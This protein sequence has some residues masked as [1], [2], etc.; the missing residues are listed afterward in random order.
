MRDPLKRKPVI[1]KGG[2]NNWDLAYS[3]YTKGETK[4]S[5]NAQTIQEEFGILLANA[6]KGLFLYFK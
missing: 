1:L 6:L 4:G 5:L 2:F 3:C